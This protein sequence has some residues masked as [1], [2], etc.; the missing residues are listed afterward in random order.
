MS[1]KIVLELQAKQNCT[2]ISNLTGNYKFNCENGKQQW[3]VRQ[4]LG[5]NLTQEGYSPTLRIFDAQT[6]K[7]N[8][9]SAF[10]Q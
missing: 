1:L 5:V 7:N 8:S 6:L 9:G 10:R 4:K 3:S 2:S